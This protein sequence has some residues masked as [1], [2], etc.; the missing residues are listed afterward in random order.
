MASEETENI[1]KYFS[2]NKAC[3][4]RVKHAGRQETEATNMSLMGCRKFM[5][6]SFQ[7]P[8]VV[9]YVHAHSS[10]YPPRDQSSHGLH[11]GLVTKGQSQFG[12][13]V[14]AQ[15]DEGKQTAASSTASNSGDG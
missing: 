10:A 15:Q 11:S 4:S 13:A 8:G 3:N 1:V 9:W 14:A 5:G 6:D 2:N 7:L 12:L